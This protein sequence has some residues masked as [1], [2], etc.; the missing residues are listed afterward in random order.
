M[1][2]RAL[3]RTGVEAVGP[4]SITLKGDDGET[5]E[6]DCDVCVWTAGVRASDQAEALGFATTEEGRVKVSPRLRV[7][8]EEGVF[9][10]GDIAE[11]RDALS[12]RAAATAQ[13]ALQQAD[14]VAWNI[15]ADITGGVPV[16]FRYHDLGEM[17]SLGNAAAS[18]AS[19]LF[20]LEAR[21]ELAHALRRGVYLLRMPTVRHKARVGRSWAGRLPGELL[22]QMAKGGKS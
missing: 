4:S 15:H 5:R 3:M 9:A 18:L 14:T 21:G 12:D 2:V 6:E 13:V 11:S 1:G 19:P 17:L 7:H 10:L 16:N 8:G 22:R 20:G